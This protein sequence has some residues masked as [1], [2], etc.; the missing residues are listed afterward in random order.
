[1]FEYLCNSASSLWTFT[2]QIDRRTLYQ[3]GWRPLLLQLA[4][5]LDSFWFS[6]CL[7]VNTLHMLQFQ[8]ARVWTWT[9]IKSKINILFCDKEMGY[10]FDNLHSLRNG[11]ECRALEWTFPSC[12]SRCRYVYDNSN[13]WIYISKLQLYLNLGGSKFVWIWCLNL[14]AYECFVIHPFED[15]KT[16]FLLSLLDFC[17]NQT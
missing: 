17:I 7:L 15:I 8:E 6:F 4:I 9:L 10:E 5:L 14:V 2:F 1:M 3:W 12:N 13:F 16:L 11:L